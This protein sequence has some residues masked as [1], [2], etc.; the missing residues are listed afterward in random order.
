MLIKGSNLNPSQKTLVLA[1]F[2]HRWTH[3]NAAQSYGGKCPG[4]EQAKIKGRF[5]VTGTP[6]HPTVWTREAWHSYHQPLTTDEKWLA[7]HAFHFNKD[8]SKL[9]NRMRFAPPASILDF[10]DGESPED[11]A[12]DPERNLGPYAPQ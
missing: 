11:A 5:I 4:C 10:Q 8:G 1:A 3:E 7:A 9:N 2:V 6:Q 12:S